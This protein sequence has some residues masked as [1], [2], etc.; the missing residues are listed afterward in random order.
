MATDSTP[1][2]RVIAASLPLILVGLCSLASAHS[3]GGGGGGSGHGGG[4]GHGSPHGNGHR[5]G[6][7]AFSRGY[8]GRR[9]G[10]GGYGWYAGRWYGGT[11][12]LGYGL[13]VAALPWY[14][15]IYPWG[16]AAYYYADDNYYEWNSGVGAYET[17]QPPAALLDQVQSQSPAMRELF[18]FPEAG[19]SNEQ[20]ARDREDCRRRA[21]KEV[22]S[23]ASADATPARH[24]DYLQ[25]EGACL[26][27]RRYSVE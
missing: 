12:R 19:Q 27:A 17:V 13:L 6:A 14:C 16:G 24:E 5:G 23:V 10:A 20:L 9:A 2:N 1:L 11:G 21:V 25:A 4:H 15:D 7:D 22:G 3:G 26:M 18:I 8:G